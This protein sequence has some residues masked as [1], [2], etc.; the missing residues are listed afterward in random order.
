MEGDNRRFL[1]QL[2]VAFDTAALVERLQEVSIRIIKRMDSIAEKISCILK[3][4]EGVKLKI[5]LLMD[6]QQVKPA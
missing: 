3:L 2:D 5:E 6:I 4:M 1:K